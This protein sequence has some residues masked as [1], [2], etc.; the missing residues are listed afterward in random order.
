[1]DPSSVRLT[2]E[3]PDLAN[4]VVGRAKNFFFLP[5]LNTNEPDYQSSLF[6]ELVLTTT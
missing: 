3:R 6:R 5:H 4:E 1:M 2:T